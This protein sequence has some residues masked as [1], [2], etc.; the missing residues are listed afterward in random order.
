MA[1]SSECILESLHKI[2]L[3]G[4]MKNMKTRT[5]NRTPK[6]LLSVFLSILMLFSSFVFV[7]PTISKAADRVVFDASRYGKYTSATYSRKINYKMRERLAAAGESGS[8]IVDFD[9]NATIS[10]VSGASTEVVADSSAP[11]RTGVGYNTVNNQNYL[12]FE[13]SEKSYSC[14]LKIVRTGYGSTRTYQGFIEKPVFYAFYDDRAGTSNTAPGVSWS[15]GTPTSS[16]YLTQNWKGTTYSRSGWYPAEK[17][18]AKG[19]YTPY[20]SSV[21]AYYSGPTVHS[22]TMDVIGVT[23]RFTTYIYYY[24][25]NSTELYNLYKDLYVGYNE[26]YYVGSPTE[27]LAKAMHAAELVLQGKLDRQIVATEED[28]GYGYCCICQELLDAIVADLK[29]V[30]IT[31]KFNNVIST[32][33]DPTEAA[34]FN[35]VS[36]PDDYTKG[37]DV[38]IN[39]ADKYDASN[40]KLVVNDKYGVKL[41][42]YKPTGSSGSRYNFNVPIT[43]DISEIVATGFTIKKYNV[44]IPTSEIYS[45]GGT[46]SVVYG[47]TGSFRIVL[48][49]AHNKANLV[50]RIDGT[51]LGRTG[52]NGDYTFTTGK[53]YGNK[54][55][56]FDNIPL[57][58]YNVNCNCGTGTSATGSDTTIEHGGKATIK[59]TVDEKYN[60]SAPSLR[61]ASGNGTISGGTRSGNTYTYTLSGSTTNTTVTVGDL[62]INK[63]NVNIPTDRTGLEIG[64]GGSHTVNYD[65]SWTFTVK[66]LDGYTQSVPNVKVNN[67]TDGFSRTFDESTNKYTYKIDNIRETK[68]VTIDNLELNKYKYDFST[69]EGYTLA[70]NTGFDHTSITHGKNYQ[71]V[72]NVDKAYNQHTPVV[73]IDSGKEVSL[74]GNGFDGEGNAFY[75][76]EVENVT[77]HDKILVDDM[78][79]NT[80]SAALPF[81]TD[82]QG[83]VKYKVVNENADENNVVNGI[84]YGTDLVF[85]VD[86][87]E[88]YNRSKVVV[89]YDGKVLEPT[90]KIYTIKNVTHNIGIDETDPKI[91]VE[92]V[93]L[94]HYYI[95]LPLETETGFVIEVAD[96]LN[97]KSVLSGT[98]FKFKFFLDP[99]YSNSNPTIKVSRDGGKHYTV[100][101]AENGNEYTINEVLSDCIVV[102]ENVKKNTYTVKFVDGETV[103][104]EHKDV[105]YGSDVSYEGVTPTR[106]TEKVSETTDEN[107]NTV[108]VERKYKFIGWSQDTTNVTSDLTVTPIFEV[109][110]VTTTTPAGGGQGETVI[111][112]KTATI[113]FISDGLTIH[114]ETVN[115]GESFLGWNEVPVKTSS[116][117]Y[118]KYEFLGWD[119]N[120]DGTPD[121]SAENNKIENVQDDIELVAVFKSNLPT[122]TVNFYNFDGSKL[123]YTADVK[124]GSRVVR[125]LY[126]LDGSPARIDNK[127]EY[128][129]SGWAY[130]KDGAKK[131]VIDKLVIGEGETAIDFF[132]AYSR[133]KITYTYKY[134]ND[135][136]VMQEGSYNFVDDGQVTDVRYTGETPNRASSKSTDYTFR[137]WVRSNVEGSRYDYIYTA[138]YAESTREYTYTLPTSDGTYTVALGEGIGETIKWNEDL[139]FTVTLDEGHDQNAPVVKSNGKLV[140]AEKVS[141]N[142]YKYVIR[143]DGENADEIK[144]KLNNITAETTINKYTV[145]VVKATNEG[146]NKDASCELSDTHFVTDYNGEVVLT[147]KLSEGYTQT[148]PVLTKGE[149]DRVEITLVS[150]EGNKYTYKLS[151]VK[152]NATITVTTK[153]NEYRVIVYNWK[154]EAIFNKNVKHGSTPDIKTPVRPADKNGAYKFIGYDTNND[155][156]ADVMV[157]ENVT[158]PVTAKALYDYN[159]KHNIDPDEN[160][161]IWELVKTDKATCTDNG[162]KH[163]TCKHGDGQKTTKVILA[164]G[165]KWTAEGEGWIVVKAPTCTETGLKSRFCCNEENAEY[166][167]CNYKE[168]NVVIPATGHHDSDGDYKC[169]DCGADLGHCSSCICHKG[170]VL[171]KVIR[172][173]CTILS[174]TFHTK[175]KCCK[176]M[177]WYGDEISSIS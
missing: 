107:G 82:E 90:G 44:N 170:N 152:S 41:G 105:L 102:V 106:A 8:E 43:G 141:D 38:S 63:Y 156:T 5:Q 59:I 94:N 168:E 98:N 80:Y 52:S 62:T 25:I 176:C 71:F 134:I 140:E 122:R 39:V 162:L 173:I 24:R 114:K 48:D 50:A 30:K 95:T 42:E 60:Q 93:K 73:K 147:V 19:T 135:G 21:G 143:A 68:N 149:D 15:V 36:V 87:H 92:G 34:T 58:K 109:S 113:R 65:G 128:T 111:T 101:N 75:V 124:C 160:P 27:K 18:T 110:E 132:A 70:D 88:Q 103:L 14:G 112:K 177:K 108:L 120:G 20:S 144:A 26:G 72:V 7:N 91:T 119:I 10:G 84:V 12:N 165:H 56:T 9:S 145:D 164:R 99:A 118:E 148:A 13:N 89:K 51:A 104:D 55:V 171:S 16:Y 125:E 47:E 133:E 151:G 127:Y 142:T 116:N 123:L 158:A 161:D 100:L 29:A 11:N 79:K 22:S 155:G 28:G 6:R 139:V 146:G 169:D 131:D 97:A 31:V 153:I 166:K 3:I 172:K 78:T 154:N 54:N 61:I 69:G 85:S 129:F 74:I 37:L 174:K 81:E 76:F 66:V 86:L 96:G 49:E 138:D 67:K 45:G 117:P 53:I 35:P 2:Y 33:S 1:S 77:A 32:R 163:Y 57:N 157:I 17:P 83:R 4:G 46:M 175:I 167:A 130:V 136:T 40:V 121:Y 115:K 137:Y 126:G 23:T 64:N 150:T 159:H